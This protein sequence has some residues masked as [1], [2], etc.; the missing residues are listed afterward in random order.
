MH[1]AIELVLTC[2]IDFFCQNAIGN[3]CQ[4]DDPNYVQHISG[5]DE[6]EDEDDGGEGG[7]DDDSSGVGDDV[8]QSNEDG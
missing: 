4:D 6:D 3:D 8:D 2:N 7:D 1:F 5:D